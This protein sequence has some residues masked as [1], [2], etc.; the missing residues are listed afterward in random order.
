[1]GSKATAGRIAKR[2]G[3]ALVKSLMR[4]AILPNPSKLSEKV[5]TAAGK[6]AADTVVARSP[7]VAKKQVRKQSKLTAH[8]RKFVKVVKALTAGGITPRDPR[9]GREFRK[10]WRYE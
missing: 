7:K 3:I 5:I 8:Q 2:V 4:R 1:M 10:L 9:Y 6:A